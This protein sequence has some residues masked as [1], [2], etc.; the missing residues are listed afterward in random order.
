MPCG[1]KDRGGKT[2]R[3]FRQGENVNR[4]PSRYPKKKQKLAI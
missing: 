4:K 1:R 3:V 2:A